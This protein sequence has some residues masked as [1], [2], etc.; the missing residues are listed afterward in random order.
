MLSIVIIILIRFDLNK[1]RAV[2]TTYFFTRYNNVLTIPLNFN[3]L[4]FKS[5]V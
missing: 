3:F 5:L 2:K 1:G 4:H